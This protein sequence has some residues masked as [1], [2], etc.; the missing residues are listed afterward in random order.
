MV[1]ERIKVVQ[2]VACKR[3]SPPVAIPCEVARKLG[4]VDGMKMLVLLDEKRKRITYTPVEQGKAR[5]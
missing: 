3:S 2:V 5:G 4:I 1:E